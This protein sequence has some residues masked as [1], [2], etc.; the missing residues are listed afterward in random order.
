MRVSIALIFNIYGCLVSGLWRI[1]THLHLAWLIFLGAWERRLVLLCVP[2]LGI[3]AFGASK[4]GHGGPFF[5]SLVAFY[6]CVVQ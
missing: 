5:F 6:M 1:G 2:L 3:C 4:D